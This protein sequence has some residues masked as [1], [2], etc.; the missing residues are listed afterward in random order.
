M[1]VVVVGGSWGGLT[2][3]ETL[4]ADLSPGCDAAVALVLHRA[5][6]THDTLLERALARAVRLQVVAVEDQEPLLPGR[7]YVA[8]PDYHLLIEEEKLALS[9]DPR[10]LFS[11]PSIDV[12]FESAAE[13]HGARTVAVLLSGANADGA[14]GVRCVRRAGGLTLVQD[15][16]TAERPEMPAAA[17]ATGCAEVVATVEQLGSLLQEIV[18]GARA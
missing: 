14:E 1:W 7:L 8:P 15:P 2:A 6:S 12:L 3:V 18:C 4:L 5:A 9:T 13:S 16:A 10:V 11:R 17:I